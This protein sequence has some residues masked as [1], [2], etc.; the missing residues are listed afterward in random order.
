MGNHAGGIF[1]VAQQLAALMG[2]CGLTLPVIQAAEA[3]GP[4]GQKLAERVLLVRNAD[5]PVSC[6]VAD[7][8]AEKR[9]IANVV[10]IHCADSALDGARETI[11]LEDYT[12]AIRRPIAEYLATRQHIDFIVLTKGIPIRIRGGESGNTA[13]E[14]PALDNC[15]AALD[16]P[17]LKDATKYH[18]IFDEARGW[19]WANRYWNAKTPF[20]HATF[21]G[22]LV[23]RLDGYT[24]NDA[25]ALVAR[26]L[27]AEQRPP[28][29]TILLDIQP[30]FGLGDPHRQPAPLPSMDIASESTWSEYNADMAH[31]AEVLRKRGIPVELDSDVR[32]VGQK[33]DLMGYF[34]WGS[35]DS[36]FS[37]DAY[38]SLSFAPGSL[39]D[40]A[41][42]TS[43]RTFLTTSGGQ[44]L[45]TDL[46]AH[47]VTGVK[48]YVNE[49]LLQACASPTI[50]CSFYTSGATLAES[51]YA[52]SRFLGWEDIVVG[53]PICRPYAKH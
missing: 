15:L 21:G 47:G 39:S 20:S 13:G 3:A 24:K 7:D 33:A 5:S 36:H 10:A 30:D 9:G 27:A 40:T 48:G 50:V 6:A 18:F 44:S 45:I 4:A 16:Y 28:T 32:F 34:S 19:A 51:F 29:G 38:Q 37:N 25:M 14:G 22:Y 42:S 1:S 35:N 46:I 8:Y 12:R 17:Q 49:P 23:T 43:A 52:G 53:D 2:V 31:A 41:V 11:S 26:A